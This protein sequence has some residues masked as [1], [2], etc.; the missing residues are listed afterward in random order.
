LITATS[1]SIG[2]AHDRARGGGPGQTCG[3]RRSCVR[4]VDIASLATHERR[5]RNL[6]SNQRPAAASGIVRRSTQ[7]RIAVGADVGQVQVAEHQPVHPAGRRPGQRRAQPVLVHLVG[8]R[9]GQLD[10]PQWQAESPGLGAHQLQRHL[11][12]GHPAG[13]GVDGDEQAQHVQVGVRPGRRQRHRAVLAGR[14]ADPGAMS[15]AH[16]R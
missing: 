8:A 15:F 16:R 2:T 3:V 11:V 10:H 5:S 6:W 4:L 1:S 9:P 12:H 7:V 14:P 13:R